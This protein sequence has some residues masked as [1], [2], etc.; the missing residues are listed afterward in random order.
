M[1]TDSYITTVIV[2]AGSARRF[3]APLPKQFCDL[4]GRPVLMHTVDAI[5]RAIPD[6]DIVLVLSAD[7]LELWRDLCQRHGYSSP[8]CVTGGDTRWQSVRNALASIPDN[9]IILVHDGAR[10]LVDGDTVDRV[11]AAARRCGAAI[12]AVPVTDS[13]RRTDT[14]APVDRSLFRAVQTP[15]AFDAGLLKDAYRRPFDP[16]FTDDASVVQSAGHPVT[17]TDGNRDNIKITYP[18][19]LLLAQALLVARNTQR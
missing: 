8:R 17:M 2:A 11:V 18:T 12:P 16:L 3:G 15:Q 6:G 19:D 7:G 5:R 4:G 13:L 14:D 9:G 10:P 1:V